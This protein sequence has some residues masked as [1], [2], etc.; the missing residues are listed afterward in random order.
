[1]I[2]L[3]FFM[4]TS[5]YLDLDMLPLAAAAGGDAQTEAAD[6]RGQRILVQ[7]D[8]AGRARVRGRVTEPAELRALVAG[9]L[10]RDPGTEVVLLPSLQADVQ[11]LALAMDVLATAGATRLHVI[12]L[13]ERP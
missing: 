11:S 9:A 4:V 5:T 10:E 3:V 2:L 12:R 8:A 13:E 7:I 6:R 1:M